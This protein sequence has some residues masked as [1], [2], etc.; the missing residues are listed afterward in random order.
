M[1][2]CVYIHLQISISISMCTLSHFSYVQLFAILWTEA[3][4]VPL[5]MGFSRPESWNGLPCPPPG[6][7]PDPRIK[8]VPLMSL[9]LAGRFFITSTTW[10]GQSVSVSIYLSD[11]HI[12][13]S[14]P[15]P[16]SSLYQGFKAYEVIITDSTLTFRAL[17]Q[18]ISS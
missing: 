18:V 15:D 2:V 17:F 12:L 11:M 10:E 16:F 6:G 8:S 9:A 7:L 1:C 14:S 13:R 4:Q 5:S 3:C